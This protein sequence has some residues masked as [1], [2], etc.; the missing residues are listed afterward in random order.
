[1]NINKKKKLLLLLTTLT[2]SIACVMMVCMTSTQQ[3]DGVL[4]NGYRNEYGCAH[5][6]TAE[7]YP[8]H[9]K[10]LM[11]NNEALNGTKGVRFIAKVSKY[12][13][14]VQWFQDIDNDAYYQSF[15]DI[16]P[17]VI[18]NELITVTGFSNGYDMT[19]FQQGDIVCFFGEV[20]YTKQGYGAYT[21]EVNSPVF[22]QW[23][24]KQNLSLLQDAVYLE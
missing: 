1:M 21:V 7:Y 17:E 10:S 13:S 18:K 3:S 11:E 19:K 15:L 4:A 9:V 24:E 22:Y 2:S 14:G 8:T 16:T 6:C 20:H 23:N 5:N 12:A